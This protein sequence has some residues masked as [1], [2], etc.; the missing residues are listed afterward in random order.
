MNALVQ[1]VEAANVAGG[2]AAELTSESG[3]ADE[4]HHAPGHLLCIPLIDEEACDAIC[5]NVGY[6]RMSSRHHRKA[7]RAGFQHGHR[8]PFA[9][10]VRSR[11][12][13]LHERASLTHLPLHDL[14]RLCPEERDRV[15]NSE[16]RGKIAA[17]PQ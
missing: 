5:H 1:C 11:D 6:S 8:R 17:H 9:V 3:V 13:V 10:A 2:I 4:R 16:R 14:M 12:R 7:Y 15:F